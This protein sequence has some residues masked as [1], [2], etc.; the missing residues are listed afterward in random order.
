MK[1]LSYNKDENKN[2]NS[3]AMSFIGKKK[4]NKTNNG[5]IKPPKS[6]TLLFQG[7]F[8]IDYRK[9]VQKCQ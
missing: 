4:K 7:G 8:F 5:K 2:T 9:S 6:S 1:K 3:R